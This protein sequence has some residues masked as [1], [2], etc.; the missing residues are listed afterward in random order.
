[1]GQPSVVLAPSKVGSGKSV[2]GE[3]TVPCLGELAIHLHHALSF[4]IDAT[5]K[6]KFQ[7]EWVL[8]HVEGLLQIVQRSR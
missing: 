5:V 1:M 3:R 4:A 2:G 7:Q 6:N 8:D